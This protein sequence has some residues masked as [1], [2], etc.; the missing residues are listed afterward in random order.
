M[1][2]YIESLKNNIKCALEFRKTFIL[3]VISQFGVF[4]SYYFLL[5]A[6]FQ[7][8]SNIRGFTIYEVLLCFGVIH[9]GFAFNETFFR[10]VDKFEDF[11][12]NGSLD[13]LLVRPQGVLFQVLCSRMDVVKV[14]RLF[15][16]LFFIVYSFI[17]LKLEFNYVNVVIVLMMM[18]ASVVIFFSLFLLM[19]AYCFVTIEGLEIKNLIITTLNLDELSAEDIDTDAPLFGDGL[20]LDS[21]DA[22]ELGLAIKG[23]YG[24]VLSA[25]DENTR[26]HFASVAAL[27]ALVQAQSKGEA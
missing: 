7:R 21:I 17:K 9:F 27:V 10:G 18:F 6:L 13:R 1:K 25:E 26:R 19:A 23:R 8:F 24:I 2:I 3:Y 22:L 4:F 14:T 5:L 20:G 12:S 16:A 11:I 15:Q